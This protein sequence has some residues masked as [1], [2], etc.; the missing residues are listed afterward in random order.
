ME[1]EN[2]GQTIIDAFCGILANL[3]VKELLIL[4]LCGREDD[5][6]IAAKLN[7][8]EGKVIEL[9]KVGTD[10]LSAYCTGLEQGLNT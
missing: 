5:A 2:V 10:K 8:S 9:F 6:V 7:I 3:S 1:I 4:Y